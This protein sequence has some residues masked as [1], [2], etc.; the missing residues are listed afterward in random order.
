MSLALY[1]SRV[2]SSDLLD[3]P[4]LRMYDKFFVLTVSA[5]ET[6]LGAVYKRNRELVACLDGPSASISTGHFSKYTNITPFLS[7]K[8]L[9]C[10]PLDLDKDFALARDHGIAKAKLQIVGTDANLVELNANEVREIEVW[11]YR[12]HGSSNG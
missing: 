3:D 7:V 1:P 11:R 8:D 5:S 10:R 6:Q 9:D 12:S 2:R 4:Y